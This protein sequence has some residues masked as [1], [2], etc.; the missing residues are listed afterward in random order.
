M[1]TQIV[2]HTAI[3]NKCERK[4][5]KKQSDGRSKINKENIKEK[6]HTNKI[7]FF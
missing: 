2:I 1:K 4:E 7:F 6:E 3:Q 5:L